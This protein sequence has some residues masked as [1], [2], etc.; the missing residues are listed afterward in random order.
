MPKDPL[1]KVLGSHEFDRDME[2]QDMES[3]LNLAL[4][5]TCKTQVEPLYHELGPPQKPSMQEAPMQE[6]NILP[7]HIRYACLVTNETFPIIIFAKLSDLQV[8]VT[9]QIFKHRKKNN[10]LEDR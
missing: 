6:P 4:I 10:W 3:C 9:L 2:P 8:E 7:T 5:E 1:D